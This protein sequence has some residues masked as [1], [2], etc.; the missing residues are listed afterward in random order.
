MALTF[1]YKNKEGKYFCCSVK[2]MKTFVIETRSGF[3]VSPDERNKV[4]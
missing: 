4:F 3:S 2:I 1:G